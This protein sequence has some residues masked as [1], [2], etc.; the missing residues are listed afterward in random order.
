M[1][2][3][4]EG[5]HLHQP[6]AAARWFPREWDVA[7]VTANEAERCQPSLR[8]E[9]SMT[10]PAPNHEF[11]TRVTRRGIFLG[12]AASLFCAPAIVHATSLMPVR[13]LILQGEL[14][15]HG[16]LERLQA[17]G[18]LSM[19]TRQRNAGLSA[20][21]IAAGINERRWM[22]KFP[23]RK[24]PAT[25]T[26]HWDATRVLG[27]IR[28]DHVIRRSDAI[29]RAFKRGELVYA[30]DYPEI[31]PVERYLAEEKVRPNG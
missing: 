7:V 19:I 27:V 31:P 12:A 11:G 10:A 6:A 20:N 13:R 8:R 16:F 30:S 22:D 25:A 1:M 14:N 5:W 24:T 18:Y 17:S 29:H 15:H 9:G 21:E 4:D 23:G 3:L 26:D 28:R 2:H